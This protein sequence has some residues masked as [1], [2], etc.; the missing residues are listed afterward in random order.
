MKPDG[1]AITMDERYTAEV[2]WENILDLEKGYF[3]DGW[4]IRE[5]LIK[6][7]TFD[8]AVDRLSNTDIIAPIYYIVA[9]TDNSGSGAIITRNQTAVNGPVINGTEYNKP[10]FLNQTGFIGNHDWY[11]VETNYDYWV[12]A[13]DSR[14][15]HAIKMM[16]EMG[17]ENVNFDNLFT[18]LSTPPVLAPGT[19]FTSL[20]RPSEEGYYNITIRYNTTS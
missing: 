16:D 20:Y 9:G 17:Q 18:V 10:L 3:P 14:R 7:K 8:E 2:P 19:V 13:K 1:F 6:D 4:L 15:D 5:A 11:I 12:P